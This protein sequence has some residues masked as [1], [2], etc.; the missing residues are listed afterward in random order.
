M[1]QTKLGTFQTELH[2]LPFLCSDDGAVGR[3]VKKGEYELAEVR[4]ISLALRPGDTFIDAGAN[5]GIFTTLAAKLVGPTGRVEA[6]EP[7]PFNQEILATNVATNNFTQVNIHRAALGDAPGTRFL[8]QS[9]NNT[10][11]HR[12]W[13]DN[14]EI[15]PTAPVKVESIDESI[16]DLLRADLMKVDVQGDEVRVLKGAERLIR[17]SPGMFLAIEY[18][19]YGLTNNGSS[20]TEFA[21]FVYNYFVVYVGYPGQQGG[22]VPIERAQ[23]LAVYGPN[24][25]QLL[26]LWCVRR[27]R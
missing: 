6:F 25:D 11:D 21:D 13:N 1:Q 7:D 9:I 4:N 16:P 24:D 12:T 2:G 14:K 15:R 19:P 3:V 27:G 18:W 17:N 22:L 23:L 20:P 8:Y 10:G 5:V 26:N